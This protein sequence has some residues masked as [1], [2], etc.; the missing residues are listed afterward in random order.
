MKIRR[1]VVWSLALAL[2][3]A[4]AYRAGWAAEKKPV[5]MPSTIIH[6]VTLKWKAEVTDAAKQ[7]VMDDLKAILADTPGV[8]NFWMRSVK[9]QPKEYSQAFVIEFENEAALKAYA[10][11]PQKKAWNEAYYAIREMSINSVTT[12]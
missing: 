7:K 9:V 5:N 1:V 3:M 2:G 8:K 6:H 4:I 12:N 10:S 11:H